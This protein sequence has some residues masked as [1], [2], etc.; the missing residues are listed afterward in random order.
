M[1]PSIPAS[2]T[3]SGA[4]PAADRAT[5]GPARGGRAVASSPASIVVRRL[6]RHPSVVVGGTLFLIVILSAVLAPWLSPYAP[7]KANLRAPLDPPSAAH[8]MGTD[9]FGRDVLSRVLWG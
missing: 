1:P 4:P 2:A 6:L 7:F 9:R 3:V 5:G 8:T